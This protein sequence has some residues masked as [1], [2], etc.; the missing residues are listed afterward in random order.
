MASTITAALTK[1][2][3]V[4]MLV[5]LDFDGFIKRYAMR[6]ISVPN[7][8]GDAKL[9]EGLI[10]NPFIIGNSYNFNSNTYSLSDVQIT[11]ANKDRLQDMEF[12]RRL[13]GS[14]GTIY[15]WCDGLDWSDINSDGII[16]KG[17]FQKSWHDQYY[18]SFR[19]IDFMKNMSKTIPTNT[20]NT[21]TWPN[22]RTE[23]GNGSVAGL[24]QAILYGDWPGGVPLKCINT[25]LHRYLVCEGIPISDDADYTATTENVYDK[26]GSVISAANYTFYPD[27]TDNLGNVAAY[28]DFTGDQT[29]NELLSCS[30]QGIQDGSGEITGTAGT[31]I[32]HPADVLYH[33][34]WHN[35][36][37]TIDDID[38]QSIKT[39]HAKLSGL[40]FA[41]IINRQVDSISIIDRLLSQCQCARFQRNGKIGVMLLDPYAITSGRLKRFDQIYRTLRIDKTP[42]ELICNNLKVYYTL[43]PS[44]GN[45]EAELIKDRTN[46]PNCETSYYDYG[47]RPQKVLN[48][49]DVQD[50]STAIAIANRYLTLYAYRHDI[51]TIEVPYWVGWDAI[52]GDVGELTIAEGSSPDGAG[53]TNEKCVLLERQFHERTILQKWWRIAD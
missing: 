26:D 16:F 21:D 41:S 4:Y 43:N 18:Y 24:P 29:S 44:T 38:V 46:N 15:I 17:Q 22:H 30:I 19:L 25:V 34:L 9:F 3:E 12:S 20:I 10:T 11:I 5:E 37:L 36:N 35:T 23:G 52:E 8:N 45:Y 42:D 7:S 13:D 53:W 48:L 50:E 32:E 49:S 39:M 33:L 1:A 28:F 2:K 51:V 14:I 31:L 40:K 6:N 27:R 47:A